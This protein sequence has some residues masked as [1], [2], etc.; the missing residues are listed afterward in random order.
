MPV[1]TTSICTAPHIYNL[2]VNVLVVDMPVY[3]LLLLVQNLPQ[4]FK[5]FLLHRW[6]C[7]KVHSTLGM[8]RMFL[9]WLVLVPAARIM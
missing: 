4:P 9:V 8:S 5:M 3:H 1:Y 7:L 6:W 2:A